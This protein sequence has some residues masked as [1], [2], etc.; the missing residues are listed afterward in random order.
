M[1]DVVTRA[2]GWSWTLAVDTQST[3]GSVDG[4]VENGGATVWPSRD[5]IP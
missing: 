3:N 4:E 5:L 1:P 2:A